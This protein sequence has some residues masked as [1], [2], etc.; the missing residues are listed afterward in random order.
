MLFNVNKN[1]NYEKKL[2]DFVYIFAKVFFFFDSVWWINGKMQEEN[3]HTP[4][5]INQLIFH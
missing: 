3:T 4:T 2:N 1:K 5:Q